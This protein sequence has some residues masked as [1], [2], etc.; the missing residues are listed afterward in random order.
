MQKAHAF[1]NLFTHDH[2]LI[3]HKLRILRDRETTPQTFRRVLGEIAGLMTYEALRELPTIDSSVETPLTTAAGRK[4]AAPITIVPILRAGLG[5][6]EGML[7][8]VP[9]ARTGHIGVQRNEETLLP[10]EYYGKLPQ[11]AATGP[12]LLVDPMLATGGSAVFAIVSLRK[13][14]CNHIVM[15]CLVAAPEGVSRL[16]E[17]HPMVP[18]HAAVLDDK[19]DENG[20]IVPGLGDAGDRAFGTL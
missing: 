6:T 20:Y 16:L 11:D 15:L 12:V 18:V 2:P 17:S 4:L 10:T 8:L 9:E 7:A 1:P 19:L 3:E 13:R 5:M 14:G